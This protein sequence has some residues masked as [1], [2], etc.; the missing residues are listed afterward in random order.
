MGATLDVLAEVGYH[1]LTIETVA[2]R[3]GV[4]KAT[5][6]RWWPTK[7]RL[8]VEALST[9]L[10]FHPVEATGDLKA[11]VRTL[12][13]RAIQV[14]V[15]SPLGR[16]LPE[17]VTDLD[18]DPESRA[19]LLTLFGPARASNLSLLY[20]AAGEGE[21][22]HDMDGALLLDMISGTVLYRQLLGRQAGSVLVDQLA[23]FIVDRRLPRADPGIEPIG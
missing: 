21:L 7:A 8:V 16:V 9:Q 18:D 11:D 2:A 19:T 20:Q 23:D 1:R 22:P 10:E 3:A 6:Y 14:F 15:R 5:V 4:G 17:M 13:Q 12:V